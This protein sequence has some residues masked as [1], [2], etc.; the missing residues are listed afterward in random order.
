VINVDLESHQA[1]VVTIVVRVV[2]HPSTVLV[3]MRAG[4][5]L[6][7]PPRLQEIVKQVYFSLKAPLKDLIS[8][9]RI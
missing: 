9:L 8:G 1:H 5:G 4:Q 3:A 7:L 6:D 2:H